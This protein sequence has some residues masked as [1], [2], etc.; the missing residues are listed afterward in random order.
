MAIEGEVGAGDGATLAIGGYVGVW[1][2]ATLVIEKEVYDDC[3]PP[4]AVVLVYNLPGVADLNLTQ[5]LIVGIYNGSYTWWNDTELVA[6]N[7][8][9]RL[10]SVPILPVARADASGTTNVFTSALCRFSRDWNATYGRFHKGADDDVGGTMRRWPPQV[11]L[12]LGVRNRGMVG[13][14]LSLP[15]TIGYLSLADAGEAGLRYARVTNHAGVYV[16]PGAAALLSAQEPR[17]LGKRLTSDLVDTHHADSYPFATYSYFI[18]RMRTM[19]DCSAAAELVRYVT[20]L[21][22]SNEAHMLVNSKGFVG[23]SDPVAELVVNRVVKV[24]T[25]EGESVYE[26]VL[27]QQKQEALASQ[28]WFGAVAVGV[29][30]AVALLAVLVGLIARQ[31]Y[32]INAKTFRDEWFIAQQHLHVPPGNYASTPSVGSTSTS[33]RPD[34]IWGEMPVTLNLLPASLRRGRLRWAT[35]RLLVSMRES[36]VHENVAR[37]H[38]VTSVGADERLVAVVEFASKGSLRDRLYVGSFPTERSISFSL[39]TDIF[40]GLQYLHGQRVV[41]GDVTAACCV[42]DARWN[43]RIAGWEWQPVERSEAREIRMLHCCRRRAVAPDVMG[44]YADIGDDDDSTRRLYRSPARLRMP[45]SA[46]TR[47][48]DVYSAAVVVHEIFTGQ[49]P[50]ADQL[51]TA[52]PRQVAQRIIADGLRPSLSEP[53]LPRTVRELLRAC[54]SLE[55]T[56]RPTA[57]KARATVAGANPN[58][59]GIVDA[60]LLSQEKYTKQLETMLAERTVELETVT[61]NMEQLL[62]RMLP[63]GLAARLARGEPVVPE[64]FESATIYFGD[65]VDF[66]SIAAAASALDVVNLLNTLYGEFDGIVEQQ[67]LYKVETVDVCYQYRDEVI[68]PLEDILLGHSRKAETRIAHDT[69]ARRS[70]IEIGLRAGS[71]RL[72]P[73]VA[74]AYGCELVSGPPVRVK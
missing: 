5:Q 63:A 50:F 33:I 22:T 35:R 12:L 73:P 38:G 57:K 16:T 59:R 15:H 8:S 19:R 14:V 21:A 43:V 46:A 32:L 31:Q 18:V 30:V 7:P 23:L 58:Q 74:P 27:R 62:E 60:M 47:A 29:P 1:E 17:Q 25:C 54:L 70:D 6:A 24:M 61:H 56:R 41:H 55:P 48:D 40:A 36:V 13:L 37:L 26:R 28:S 71:S 52:T 65:I 64:Y 42:V 44:G 11:A 67:D 39:A 20:W 10:P 66:T 72:F 49:P 9:V 68:P 4:S 51:A 34:A 69:E 3:T 45:R 2:G 53:T